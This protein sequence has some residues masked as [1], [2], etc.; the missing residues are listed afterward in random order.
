MAWRA[1]ARHA[2]MDHTAPI[3]WQA[4]R[5]AAHF[6]SSGLL[7]FVQGALITALAVAQHQLERE[8]APNTVGVV[9]Y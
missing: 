4:Q 3:P 7:S 6:S 8:Q 1:L 9:F 5:S 2:V